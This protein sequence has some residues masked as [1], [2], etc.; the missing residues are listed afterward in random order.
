M[1]ILIESPCDLY[2]KI[3]NGFS[4]IYRVIQKAVMAKCSSFGVH[5]Q[6]LGQNQEQFTKY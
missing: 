6:L 3:G 5:F 1:Y 2:A 4:D